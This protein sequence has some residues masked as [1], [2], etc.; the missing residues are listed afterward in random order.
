MSIA[1]GNTTD[2]P[3]NHR[4]LATIN[5]SGEGEYCNEC[6]TE[7]HL[8]TEKKAPLVCVLYTA[9][10]SLVQSPGATQKPSLVGSFMRRVL[11]RPY[12]DAKSPRI[13][14]RR[15]IAQLLVHFI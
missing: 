10:K 15:T 5:E 12:M 6:R 11:R 1:G 2:D 7:K 4:D 14:H 13:L 8:G 9:S 3:I